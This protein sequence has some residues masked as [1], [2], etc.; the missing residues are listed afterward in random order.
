MTHM[1][2]YKYPNPPLLPIEDITLI[3]LTLFQ[4]SPLPP[5][6][7]AELRLFTEKKEEITSQGQQHGL[8]PEIPQT[9]VLQVYEPLY[10]YISTGRN[11]SDSYL[12]ILCWYRRRE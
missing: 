3:H 4:V 7:R 8:H 12:T 11:V 2:F 10:L 9:C 6:N 5:N 1:N